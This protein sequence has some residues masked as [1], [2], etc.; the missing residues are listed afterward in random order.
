MKES[1]V[2]RQ[3]E[4]GEKRMDNRK[5]IQESL[6]YIEENLKADITVEELAEMSGFSIYHYYRLFQIAVGMPVMQYIQ[7]RRLLNATY[8]IGQGEAVT[9]AA[10]A[11]GFDTHAGFYKAFKRE[12]GYTPS[13]FLKKYEAKKPYKIN[14]FQEEHIMVTHKK[15]QEILKNWNLQDEEIKDIYYDGSGN[16]NDNACYVGDAY[17]L[18]FSANQGK[19]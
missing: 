19:L 13:Q 8:E 7:R 2:V 4:E 1:D 15:L 11:Y 6:D 14:L 18:K 9:D 12:L 5:I 16:R 17:V 3:P 10:L